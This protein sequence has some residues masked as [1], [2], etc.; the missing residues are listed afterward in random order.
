MAQ[1]VGMNC[2][3]IFSYI[4]MCMSTDS[5][6]LGAVTISPSPVAT[7]CG[8]GN[9]LEVNCTTNASILIWSLMYISE[10]GM[11]ETHSEIITSNARIQPTT[12]ITSSVITFSRRSD[13][14][15]TP[16]TSSMAI[17]SVSMGLNGTRITCMELGATLEATTVIYIVPN[18]NGR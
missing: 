18:L 11:V 9:R 6:G 3:K 17:G 5:Y 2:N 10:S 4:K 12:M 15:I 16:L 8:V 7:V 14:R 13:L 1:M